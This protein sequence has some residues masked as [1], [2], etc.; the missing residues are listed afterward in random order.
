MIR[1]IQA[2]TLLAKVKGEDG[3]FGLRYNMNIYR[4]CQHQCIY[5][6]SRSECYG[7]E[8]FRDVL[9]KAN[10]LEVLA[11]ELPA[12]RNKGRIGTGS[13]SDPYGPVEM[14]Y[15]LTGRALALIAL[16]RFPVH[17]LTKSDLVRRDLPTLR[18]MGRAGASVSFTITAADDGLAAKLEPGAP[19]PSRRFA[20][21]RELAAAGVHTGTLMMPVLPFLTDT[22]ANIAAIVQGTA[23]A[24][25]SY[26]V[27]AFGMT[28]RDR[29]RA[30]FTRLWTGSF[31]A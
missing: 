1:E 23:A 4:G 20:A 27:P 6:D 14:Q 5:C 7:I 8:D 13:M 17:I 12:K 3:W 21:M 2:K 10:A 30:Y 31:P 19:P 22:P 29:Q 18:E 28:M 24:G 9:V 11:R 25:G 16:H 15:K 26:V